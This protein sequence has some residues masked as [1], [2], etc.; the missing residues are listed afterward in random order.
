MMVFSALQVRQTK[1]AL[2][3]TPDQNCYVVRP[4]A[5]EFAAPTNRVYTYRTAV[6]ADP[7]GLKLNH[8]SLQCLAYLLY[9][10]PC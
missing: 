5:C 4:I 9:P 10:G 7:C 1:M 3:K 6:T 2:V 8:C